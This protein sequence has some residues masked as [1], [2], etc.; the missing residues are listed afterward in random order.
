MLATDPRH[1][2]YITVEEGRFS[3][4]TRYHTATAPELPDCLFQA[5]TPAKAKEGLYDVISHLVK[6]MIARGEGASDTPVREMRHC[7]RGADKGYNGVL[8]LPKYPRQ[9][10]YRH[11][12]ALHGRQDKHLYPRGG[13]SYS[14]SDR[15]P[16]DLQD[17]TTVMARQSAG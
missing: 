7:R 1:G 13:K 5:D 16:I 8:R 10:F 12:P 3:D 2:Y 15:A 6:L 4:G 14:Q 11:H 17:C 9:S